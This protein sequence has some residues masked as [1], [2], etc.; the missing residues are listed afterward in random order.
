MIAPRCKTRESICVL[1]S[2][3]GS[4]AI[5]VPRTQR[6]SPRHAATRTVIRHATFSGWLRD[7]SVNG[8]SMETSRGLRIGERYQFELVDDKET[9]TLEASVRWC[10]LHSIRPGAVDG[11]F[12][13]L[14]LTGLELT[15]STLEQPS[16]TPPLR[17][18]T[19]GQWQ[20][21]ASGLE[22]ELPPTSLKRPGRDEP[23]PHRPSRLSNRSTRP[24]AG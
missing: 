15:S 6:R 24:T 16:V 21:S 5:Q 14:F 22:R 9:I 7:Y 4:V 12:E 1:K 23:P 17:P 3:G 11:D 8:F 2:M 19:D 13:P 20:R 18:G 10:R